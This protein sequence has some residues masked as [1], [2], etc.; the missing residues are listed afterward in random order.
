MRWPWQQKDASLETIL[1]HIVSVSQTISGISVTPENCMESPTVHAIV[2]AVQNRLAISPVHVLH[3]STVNGRAR[4]EPLPNHPVA[5]LLRKP[6]SW[7]TPEEYFA[8]SASSLLRYGRFHASKS[9]GSTGPVMELL[10][11]NAGKVEVQQDERT[12]AVQFKYDNQIIDR[13]RMHYVR[14]G[15]R[16][17][18]TGDSPITDIRESIALEIAAERHGA[19]FFGNGAM[20]M[21][22]FQLMQGFSE[23]K[24]DEEK[25]SFLEG[26]NESFSGRKKFRSMMLPKGMELKDIAVQNDK[27]QFIET[28]RFIRTV[29]AGAM[30]VPPHLVGDLERATF[31]NVEQQDTDF[32]I[33]VVMPIAKR[34]ESAMERDLL[35]DDDRR[36]GVIIRFNLD[37]VQRADIK[38]RAEAFSIER[39]WGA[40]N[41]N[42]YREMTN[43]NPISE[44]DGGE[45]FI[46]PMNM[47][48]AGDE[49]IEDG[50]EDA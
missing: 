21:L 35:T 39:Q 45:D 16:D 6:N 50:N 17:F 5:R 31:N 32:T 29:I 26:F 27:A 40:I 10:P 3:K 11:L 18:L 49:E 14:L 19:A 43:R 12:W 30:G 48:V 24:T 41:V 23:F 7:Q 2:T 20:P 13:S 38:T 42:E 37:A 15:A 25:R 1:R 9:R 46:R 8:D 44:E 22:Y 4:K 36:S 47:T 33:N 34:M 28:R